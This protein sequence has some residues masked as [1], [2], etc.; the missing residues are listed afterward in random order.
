MMSYIVSDLP[1]VMTA[2]TVPP[3]ILDGI[4]LNFEG[5]Y[6][7]LLDADCT[8]SNVTYVGAYFFNR[9]ENSMYSVSANKLALYYTADEYE[10]GEFVRKVYISVSYDGDYTFNDQKY[11]ALVNFPD[12]GTNVLYENVEI[13]LDD[14]SVEELVNSDSKYFFTTV[15]TSTQI[16]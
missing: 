15:Y 7:E 11:K 3:I 16:E 12:G 14:E 9:V 4:K 8:Y 13:D 10:D 1:T 2:E 5:R 6:A